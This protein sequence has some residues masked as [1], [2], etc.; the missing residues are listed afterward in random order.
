MNAIGQNPEWTS[1]F[2]ALGV[3]HPKWR[4]EGHDLHLLWDVH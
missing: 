4:Y 2:E 3:R 1:T